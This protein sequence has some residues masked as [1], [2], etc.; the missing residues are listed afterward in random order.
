MKRKKYVVDKDFQGRMVMK[1]VMLIVIA[2]IV[3]G[4]VSYS[5]AIKVEKNSK[6]QIFG[7]TDEYKGDIVPVSRIDVVRP[8]VIRSTI[9][10]G[11]LGMIIA[12]V[13]MF[14]YSHRLAG[15]V[16]R[17]EKHLEEMIKGNYEARLHFR[18]KDEFKH[19]ADVINRLE[20]KLK[21]K[22]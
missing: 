21:E 17:L 10:G 12:A 2:M 13:I 9:I 7:V 18:K 20:D 1:V 11:I 19:L 8:V 5:I 16:Y 6:M 15:P 14:L 22:A 4:V 3:S